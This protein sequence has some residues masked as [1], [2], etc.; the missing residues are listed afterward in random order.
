MRILLF[1]VKIYQF[2]ISPISQILIP[3]SSC[4]FYPSCSQY[5]HEAFMKYGPIRGATK[6]FWRI[7][8]CNPLAK[9]GI[10]LV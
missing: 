6:T 8:K 2:I 7:L 5:G 3:H 4:R 9:G 10:D 1:T